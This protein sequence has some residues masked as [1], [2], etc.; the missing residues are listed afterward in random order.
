MKKEADP[1]LE[2]QEIE[3]FDFL[4]IRK[5]I[6]NLNTKTAM[7]SMCSTKCHRETWFLLFVLLDKYLGFYCL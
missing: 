2:V 5:Q 7:H 3:N 1:E 6:E 4:L